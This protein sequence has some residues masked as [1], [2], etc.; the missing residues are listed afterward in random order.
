MATNES[1]MKGS[2]HSASLPNGFRYGLSEFSDYGRKGYRHDRKGR[3]L[4]A[5]ASA[6]GRQGN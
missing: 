4:E 3:E 5:D 2:K 6:E 1:M